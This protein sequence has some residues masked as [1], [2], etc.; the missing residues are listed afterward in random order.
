MGVPAVR[1]PAKQIV[2]KYRCVY[3]GFEGQI[4]GDAPTGRLFVEQIITR[5]DGKAQATDMSPP[6]YR[7]LSL[8]LINVLKSTKF[9][10][11]R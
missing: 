2:W 10:L 8:S 6:L 11:K 7:N 4:T 5:Q 9:G 3:F 1:K